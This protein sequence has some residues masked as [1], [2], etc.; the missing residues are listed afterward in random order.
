MA[1]VV[2]DGSIVEKSNAFVTVAEADTYHTDRANSGWTGTDA[3]KQAAIIRA[4]DYIEQTYYGRWLGE[5]VSTT[6]SLSWPRKCVE[7]IDDDVVP[8]RL[9]SAICTLALEA[10]SGDLNPALPRGGGV[11][12]EKVDVIEVEY[13]D[14]ATGKTT[15]PAIDGMLR[16]LIYFSSGYNIKVVRV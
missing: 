13:M 15:R 8:D 14:G 16:S 3:V 6:Q 1:F 9:K 11:K 5:A 10:L 12:R 7:G 4:T 2:E